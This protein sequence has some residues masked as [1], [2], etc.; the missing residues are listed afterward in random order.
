MSARQTLQTTDS[1]KRGIVIYHGALQLIL[2]EVLHTCL[3]FTPRW[4]HCLEY[5]KIV[6]IVIVKREPEQLQRK[7][8]TANI[9]V[10]GS[11][12]SEVDLG[13]GESFDHSLV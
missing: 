9:K 13:N 2:Y 6:I 5:T 11:I 12:S 3:D 8:K 10:I 4:Q 1:L 7:G